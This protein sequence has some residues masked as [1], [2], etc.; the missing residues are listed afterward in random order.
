MASI[1]P[2]TTEVIAKV[3]VA[4]GAH[5]E[6]VR[7]IQQRL[8][9]LGFNCGKT[10]A[11]PYFGVNTL[12]AVLSFQTSRVLKSDGIVGPLTTKQLLE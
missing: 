7:W 12:A 11:D 9:A 1:G 4:I 2:R 6:L 10:G 8:I 3:F 5:N